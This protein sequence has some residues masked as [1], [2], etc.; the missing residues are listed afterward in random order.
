[1]LRLV[2]VPSNWN[3]YGNLKYTFFVI[4]VIHNFQ[5]NWNGDAG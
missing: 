2:K 1:M 3:T 4:P 5:N